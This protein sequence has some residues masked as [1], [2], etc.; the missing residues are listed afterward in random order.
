MAKSSAITAEQVIEKLGLQPL[1]KEGGMFGV[2]YRSDILAGD[3]LPER[4]RHHKEMM[5]S[6]LPNNQT[7]RVFGTAIYFLLTNDPDS[8]SALHRLISDEIYHFYLGD[9][10]E[11]TLLFPD[12]TSKRLVLGQDILNKQRVQFVVPHGVWQGSR[13][14]SGGRFALLGCTMAPGFVERDCEFAERDA[15]LAAYPNE[16]EH[17]HALTRVSENRAPL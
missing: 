10:V 6:V 11:M 12:G 8:F 4:Y 16:K 14:V 3:A 15:L 7:K 13:L 1:P 2:T 5:P 9:P 17:I